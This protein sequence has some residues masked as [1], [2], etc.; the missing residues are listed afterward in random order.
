MIILRQ[1]ILDDLKS[2]FWWSS[3]VSGT[4]KGDAVLDQ[5]VLT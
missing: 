2:Y 5:S 4:E 3:M 1:N